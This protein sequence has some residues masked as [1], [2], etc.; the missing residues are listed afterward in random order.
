MQ[1]CR[2]RDEGGAHRYDLAS[3]GDAPDGIKAF[4]VCEGV[5]EGPGKVGLVQEEER[6]LTHE[7]GLHGSHARRDAVAAHEKP[8]ADLVDRRGDD[9]DLVRGTAPPRV[10][11]TGASQPDAARGF[12]RTQLGESPSHRSKLGP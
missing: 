10:R 12:L 1:G 2:C 6:V 7:A 5:P 11:G 8:R 4:K 3:W 9:L